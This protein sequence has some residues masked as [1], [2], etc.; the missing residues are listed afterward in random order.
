MVGVTG[1]SAL[2]S[3]MQFL[4]EVLWAVEC[5]I[6]ETA[7]L[8]MG[9][10]CSFWTAS[11]GLAVKYHE[12]TLFGSDLVFAKA[13][14]MKTGGGVINKYDEYLLLLL[15]IE[16]KDIRTLRTMDVIQQTLQIKEKTDFVFADCV[17]RLQVS[18]K[19][20]IPYRFLIFN[21]DA[22]TGN[23]VSRTI[24]YGVSY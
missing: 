9:N 22:V 10:Q 15:L 19:A 6:V 1:I 13:K 24:T 5:A 8:F 17:G 23:G 21:R 7:A 3:L 14:S 20:E 16:N 18:A 4:I 11:S 12:L 2:V